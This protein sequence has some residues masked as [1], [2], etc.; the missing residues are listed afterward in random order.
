MFLAGAG[1][2]VGLALVRASPVRADACDL[3]SSDFNILE[4]CKSD[5]KR[6]IDARMGAQTKN[7]GELQGLQSQIAKLSTQVQALEAEIGV[8]QKA[9]GEQDQEFSNRLAT[10]A[11]AAQSIYVRQQTAPTVAAVILGGNLDQ[12]MWEWGVY[13]MAIQRDRDVI[14]GV[15]T[16]LDGLRAEKQRLEEQQNQ[17]AALKAQVDSQEKVLATE[18][19]KVDQAFNQWQT[20]IGQLS[21]RQQEILTAKTGLFSTSVGDV[22]PADDSASRP[23][24]NPG[25][26]PAFAAFSFGAPHFKGMSQYGAFGRAKAGQNAEDILH[27]YYGGGVTINK[28]YSTAINIAVAGYG[29]VDIETYVKRIYE[30]PGSWGDQGGMEALKAQAVAA[31]S[32]A[33]AYTNN[34]ARAI[35]ATESCQVYRPANK[36]GSWDTAVDATRGWVMTVGGQPFSAWYASTSGG[37]QESYTDTASGYMTPG[38]WDTP[39]GI[40]GWTSQ[41]YEKQADSPWFYKGWYRTRSGDSCGRSSPWLTGEEMADII[42]AWVVLKNGSDGRVTPVGGCWGGNPYSMAEL[43]GKGGYSSVSGVSVS[44][45]DGGYTANVRFDTNGGVVDMSGGD[46]KKVFNLRAPGNIALMSG[47]FN[48]GKK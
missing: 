5:L 3:N 45:S 12:A 1:L 27:A 10:L 16:K 15:T 14:V 46:F 25:F 43:R 48:I 38:F 39:S 2:V 36:G 26:S 22:P 40:S 20:Q 41:A 13:R 6:E 4:I 11:E 32:Y 21:A 37:Y 7:K 29:T 47:L 35:C 33:L 24:Y 17:L 42:N 30:M 34:G 19:A 8:R 31:R 18:V 44:Y 9:I 23:D 28:G